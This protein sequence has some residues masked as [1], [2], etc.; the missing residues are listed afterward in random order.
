MKLLYVINALTIGGA[1]IL[2]LDLVKN[3][4]SCGNQVVVAAFRDGPIG[5][6]LQ[7]L[8]VRVVILG[9]VFLDF[10]A[11]YKLVQL[12]NE[13]NPDVIHSHLFRATAWSR[14]A[15]F[16]SGKK[17]KLVT[18]V[19]G[20]ETSVYHFVDGL[21]V[22]LSGYMLFPSQFLA[23]WYCNSVKKL[24]DSFYDVIYPGVVMT[25][26]RI[27]KNHKIFTIGT[28]SRLHCIKGID[29][30]IR[31][32]KIL[33]DKGILFKLLIGGGG[34]GKDI[35]EKLVDE[36]RLN[37][38]CYFIDDVSDKAAYLDGLS[39]F[40]APSRKEAF[41]INICEA[42]ERSL[43]VVAARVGGIPEVVCDGKTGLLCN[44]EDPED[45]AEKLILLI[46]D[47]D[48]CGRLG[49]AGRKRVERLFDRERTMKAHMDLYKSLAENK[50][51]HFAIS[52][53][54]LGGGERLAV[55]LIKSLLGRGW[56]I[57]A[58]CAGNPL[59]KELLNLGVETSVASMSMGGLLFAHKLLT[60]IK[61]FKPAVISSHLNKASLF[62]GLLTKLIGVPCVSHVHG[63][64]KKVYYQYSLKQIAVSSAVKKH[65]ENQGLTGD[66]L[67][68]INNCIDK[69]AV[70]VRCFPDRPL[71]ISITAKLHANKG[72]EWALKAINDNISRLN[73]GQINIF[74]DGPE[75]T[76][77]ETLCASLDGLKGKIKFYG[78]VNDPSLYYDD[79]D[80]AMLPSLGEGIPLSLLEVMRLGIPCV[81]TNVGGVP[82]IIVN[83]ESGL[84]VE[85]NDANALV[86]AI[87]KL[88]EKNAYESFSKGAFERFKAVNDHEKMIS[89][90]ESLLLEFVNSK[91]K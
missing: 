27:Y 18:T 50:H 45:L 55:D 83:G 34:K 90:F 59:Y 16:V 17:T 46:N 42:M 15:K 58:T 30:L 29:L 14:F 24:P 40:V 6:K 88:S 3:S 70:G 87:L 63:L 43:P 91:K 5:A 7:S 48:L 49:S 28:L 13:F 47:S 62:A 26:A 19:H 44:P 38:V 21:M 2:L 85:P 33:K 73:I 8:G 35:L 84:L 51:V 9:E 75:R 61:K 31:A 25:P 23:D 36:L 1:Q 56:K 76:K 71:N 60:D 81:S 82:E 57:T 80:L 74:G 77:L 86:E 66:S 10:V 4:V 39:A 32:A 67:V 89:D 78:F 22:S 41:G 72:H 79:V 20:A 12:I 69:P 11:C 37:D 68:A 52:S 53:R 54:E 64:N 65:L